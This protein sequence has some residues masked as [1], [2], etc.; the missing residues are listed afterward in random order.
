M[1]SRVP[2]STPRL[3]FRLPSKTGEDHSF[4]TWALHNISFTQDYWYEL[5]YHFTHVAMPPRVMPQMLLVPRV[6]AIF[7]QAGGHSW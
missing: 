3:R 5:P 4:I 7:L 2:H 1:W 6:T